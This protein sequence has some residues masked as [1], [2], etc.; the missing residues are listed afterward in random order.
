MDFGYSSVEG[1]EI[2]EEPFSNSTMPPQLTEASTPR[3][4]ATLNSESSPTSASDSPP[5]DASWED[6]WIRP[7]DDAVMVYVPSG[8][9]EMGSEWADEQPVHT[10]ALDGFW[11]D[12]TEFTNAQF[13]NF[14]NAKGNQIDGGTTWLDVKDKNA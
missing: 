1:T 14:S 9:F 7:A 6:T 11:I 10:V 8:E 2:L 4:S 12:K 5:H 13:A 3:P